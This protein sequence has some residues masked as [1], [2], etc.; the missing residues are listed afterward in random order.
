MSSG[1]I[2]E[3]ISKPNMKYKRIVFSTHAMVFIGTNNNIDSRSVP[4]VALNPS[5]QYGGHYFMSLYS[6]KRLHSYN[7]QDLPIDKD[8]IDRVQQLAKEEGAPIM[9]TALPIFTWKQRDTDEEYDYNDT[10]QMHA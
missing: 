8:M 6:S 4:V 9:E 10:W 2:V 7:W 1:T 3:G 5:N